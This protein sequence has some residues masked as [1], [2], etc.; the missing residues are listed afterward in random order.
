MAIF[1][2]R[3]PQGS[4]SP[5][6]FPGSQ[7]RRHNFCQQTYKS[8]ARGRG[9]EY[10]QATAPRPWEPVLTS[11]HSASLEVFA[12]VQFLLRCR[13]KYHESDLRK[14]RRHFHRPLFLN[15]EVLHHLR[16]HCGARALLARKPPDSSVLGYPSG[17]SRFRAE[18]AQVARV[19]RSRGGVVPR[20]PS[21]TSRASRWAGLREK[22]KDISL[23]DRS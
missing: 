17:P 21:K 11:S 10:W 16:S 18:F 15:L 8:R 22:P 12:R 2:A 3:A 4:W 19:P 23:I 13:R 9:A 6:T 20:R 7:S 5:W 14:H 1:R